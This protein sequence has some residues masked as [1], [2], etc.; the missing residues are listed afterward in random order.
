M[1]VPSAATHPL[2]KNGTKAITVSN[3]LVLIRFSCSIAAKRNWLN[4]LIAKLELHRGQ[5]FF[6]IRINVEF[7]PQ[8]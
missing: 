7:W 2:G 3:I 6:I 5:Q 4:T 1:N 8:P